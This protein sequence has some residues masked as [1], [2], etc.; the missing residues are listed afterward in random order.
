MTARKKAGKSGRTAREPGDIRKLADERKTQDSARTGSPERQSDRKSARD[1]GLLLRAAEMFDL[2]GEVVAGVARIEI[3][4]GREVLIENH[5]GI[6]EYGPSEID[7]NSSGVIIRIQGDDLE[8]RA[9][10]QSELSIRGL[11]LSIEFIY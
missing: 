10:T 3:T 2:P 9:M 6:L 7:V 1:A 4:G 8:I 11:V 5:A